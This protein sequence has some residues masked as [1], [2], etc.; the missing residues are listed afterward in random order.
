[1]PSSK[2]TYLK[3]MQW[4]LKASQK[5]SITECNVAKYSSAAEAHCLFFISKQGDNTVAI[6]LCYGWVFRPASSL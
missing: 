1:M 6:I 4:F 2:A 5:C 3:D